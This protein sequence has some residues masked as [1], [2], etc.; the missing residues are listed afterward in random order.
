MTPAVEADYSSFSGK[1]NW[2][3]VVVGGGPAGLLVAEQLAEDRL[4]VLVLEAGPV[5][6]RPLPSQSTRFKKAVAP[7]LAVDPKMWRYKSA[8]LETNWYR[9]RAGGG[10]TLLWAGWCPRPTEDNLRTASER[11][12]PW[13]IGFDELERLVRRVEALMGVRHERLDRSLAPVASK[14]GLEL[15]P[16]RG[17]VSPDNRRSFIPLDWHRRSTIRGHAVATRVVVDRRGGVSAIEFVD[18]QTGKTHGVHCRAVV[19]CASPIETARILLEEGLSHYVS[20]AELVGQGLVDH[21]VG[22]QLL[23]LPHPVRDRLGPLAR[24]AVVS[25]RVGGSGKSKLNQVTVEIRGPAPLAEL[26]P[27]VHKVAGVDEASVPDLSYVLFRPIGEMHATPARNVRLVPDATDS[28]GR[29]VP[30]V[31]TA[32]TDEDR[33]LAS[34]MDEL[35]LALVQTMT[36]PG[37]RVVRIRDPLAQSLVANEAGTARMGRDPATSVVDS[38]GAV[39]GL[40]GLYVADSSV[41]PT[42]TERHATLA[43]LAFALRTA[44]R[45]RARA[46]AGDL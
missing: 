20:S 4:E 42:A 30:V 9:V 17:A 3:V 43:A 6:E 10:R 21:L 29:P 32:F 13:A 24:S 2:D 44:D 31:S 36:V 40:R 37:C 26:D 38:S 1:E 34:E 41:L 15:V 27:V 16:K 22:G 19:L 18:T 12:T 35:A 33:A 25:G 23:I 39:R 14:L 11:G 28:L 45:M 46:A 7:L 8:G 5:R